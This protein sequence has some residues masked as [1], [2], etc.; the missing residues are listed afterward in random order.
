MSFEKIAITPKRAIIIA[1]AIASAVF[2]LD[3]STPLGVAGG[4]PYVFLV[5]FGWIFRSKGA[6]FILA[7][8]GSILTILGY[9]FS[10]EGH[11]QCHTGR[12]PPQVY[13]RY[14]LHRGLI[15]AYTADS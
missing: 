11:L 13:L 3:M 9:L 6:F 2:V 5:I 15:E 4:V 12:S 8:V 14:A 10:P 7:F 1:V